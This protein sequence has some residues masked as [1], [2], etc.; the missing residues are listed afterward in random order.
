[1]DFIRLLAIVE[2]LCFMYENGVVVALDN[3]ININSKNC[4]LFQKNHQ[5]SL[6]ISNS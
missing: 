4:E 5:D 6:K 2:Y 3:L 1:M